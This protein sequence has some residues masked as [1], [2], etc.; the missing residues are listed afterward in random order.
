MSNGQVVLGADANTQLDAAEMYEDKR[1]WVG[2]YIS[3]D[4]FDR[5][6]TKEE[7]AYYR[8]EH[9]AVALFWEN[10]HSEE[11]WQGRDGREVADVSRAMMR[12]L[13]GPTGLPCIYTVDKLVTVRGRWPLQPVV[14]HF[15][16][17][18]MAMH[19]NR[20]WAYGDGFILSVLFRLGLISGAIQ[21]VLFDKW[22]RTNMWSK[23]HPKAWGRQYENADLTGHSHYGAVGYCCYDVGFRRLPSPLYLP[24]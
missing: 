12:D 14:R 11:I 7:L 15:R 19:V 21:T 13:Y 1:L 4:G 18:N 10:G 17:L 2:R 20:I 5:N 6:L 24:A 8:D 23:Q 3:D 22:R 9:M 16:E